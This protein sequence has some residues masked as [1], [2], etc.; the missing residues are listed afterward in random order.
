VDP[1]TCDLDVL[2]QRNNG[3]TLREDDTRYGA[4]RSPANHTGECRSEWRI[5]PA[6]RLGI[7]RRPTTSQRKINAAAMNRKFRLNGVPAIKFTVTIPRE[8]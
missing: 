5:V 7:N 1:Q 2:L 4:T 6:I 3:P 8:Q